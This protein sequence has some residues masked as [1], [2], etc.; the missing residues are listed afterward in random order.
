M[1]TRKLFEISDDPLTKLKRKAHY[2]KLL[3]EDDEIFQGNEGFI[4][5][6]VN[7]LFYENINGEYGEE[8]NYTLNPGVQFYER[9]LKVHNGILVNPANQG[10][11]VIKVELTPSS[12]NSEGNIIPATYEYRDI[13]NN[14]IVISPIGY[15]DYFAYVIEHEPVIIMEVIKINIQFEDW[16]GGLNKK[17]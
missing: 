9:V 8:V 17:G 11:P 15:Y 13:E 7:I 2:R 3:I 1:R 5:L 16:N 4:R 14:Q 6:I 12:S 10:T